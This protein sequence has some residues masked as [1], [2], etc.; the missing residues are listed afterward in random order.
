MNQELGR[1]GFQIWIDK[2]WIQT[3]IGKEFSKLVQNK[4]LNSEKTVYHLNWKK[5][6]L[7]K[8][9]FDKQQTLFS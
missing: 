4:S 2:V 1:A 3:E 6:V 5:E 7:E 8:L 9:N